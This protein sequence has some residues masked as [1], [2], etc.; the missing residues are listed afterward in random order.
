MCG[1]YYSYNI[2]VVTV[3]NSILLRGPEQFNQLDVE[4]EHFGHALLSTQGTSPPQPIQNKHGTL[5]YNGSTYNSKHNDT[6]WIVNNLDNRLETTVDLIKSLIG[7]YSVTYVTDTHIVFAV[8][9][10]SSKNL[11]FYYD[12]ETRSFIA[13]STVDFVLAHVPSAVR[14]QENRIY[15]IDKHTFEL[16]IQTT[17]E[18]NLSQTVNNLDSVFEAFEQAIKDRHEPQITTY[19]LS[20]GID[21]GVIVCCARKFFNADMYTVSKIGRED[22]GVLSERMSLQ[23]KPLIDRADDSAVIPTTKEMF[24]LYNFE[25]LKDQNPQALT[26]ILQNHFVPR[27]QKICISGIG[28]DELY[29][30]YQTDKQSRGRVGKI[31]GGWPS[32]LRTI[33]P[34]HDYADSRLHRQ[35]HRSD[36][37]CGHHGIE[38]RYPLTDQRLFQRFLNTSVEIKNRGYKHWQVQYM[39]EHDYPVT[40]DKTR[41]AS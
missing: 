30:D 18:W 32:D 33:Y 21:A 6:D 3:S 4:N 1:Y 35:I 31:I 24:K 13:G 37:I 20:A 2:P 9:Q 40:L 39:K 10:W 38:G 23:L 22:P 25:Y 34:W 29:D 15:T 19:M 8:D 41:F 28:G 26:S 14:A 27:K 12:R 17:T 11:F 16:D 7:E 5:V 36:M